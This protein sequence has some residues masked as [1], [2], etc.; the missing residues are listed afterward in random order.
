MIEEDV[1]YF[2]FYQKAFGI[3]AQFL[4]EVRSHF[5]HP[6]SGTLSYPDGIKSAAENAWKKIC[7][8]QQ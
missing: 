4:Q 6:E 8:I 2:E 1:K 7:E 5:K 3:L